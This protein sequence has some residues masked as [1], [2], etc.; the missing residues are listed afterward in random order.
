MTHDTTQFDPSLD[1]QFERIVDISPS[2]IWAAWTTPEHIVNWFTPKPW[3]TI[4]CEID[5]RPGGIFRTVML[6]PEGEK[7]PNRGCYLEIVP[8]KKLVW[9]NTLEPGYRPAK[10][11]GGKASVSFLFTAVVSIEAHGEGSKYSATV[12]H[13]SEADCKTHDAMGFQDGWGKAFDQ[14]VAYMKT[15]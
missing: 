6:S 8:N 13:G 11:S 10:P 5:L 9:T 15:R 7:F 2:L 4:D 14:L 1:L 12:I 3:E